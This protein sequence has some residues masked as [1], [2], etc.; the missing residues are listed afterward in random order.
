MHNRRRCLLFGLDLVLEAVHGF[1]HEA[2][3]PILNDGER[4]LNV[5]YQGV[6]IEM[7]LTN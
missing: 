7:A 2:V 3:L 1:L 4:S 5:V 6:Y